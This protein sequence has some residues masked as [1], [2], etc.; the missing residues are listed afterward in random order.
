MTLSDCP[1]GVRVIVD[2][3]DLDDRHRFRLREIGL[4][5]GVELQVIQRGVFGGRVIAF[6]G[7]RVALDG[8][9][10]RAVHVRIARG[11]AERNN[12]NGEMNEC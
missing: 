6:G 10:A 8:N 9:T 4:A 12:E 5:R 2:D 7:E 11:E 3:V 1:R